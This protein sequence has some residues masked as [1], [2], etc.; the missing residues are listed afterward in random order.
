M[1][2]EKGD[3]MRKRVKIIQIKDEVCASAELMW[4]FLHLCRKYHDIFKCSR[5]RITFMGMNC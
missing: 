2:V 1:V 5:L 4:K 3:K